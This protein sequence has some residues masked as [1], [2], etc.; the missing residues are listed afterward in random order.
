MSS[1]LLAATSTGFSAPRS[2]AASSLSPGRMPVR[3]STTRTAT[4]DSASAWRA[5]DCTARARSSSSSRSTPPV[6]TSTKRRPFH[7]V[8]I[9]L[10]SRVTPDCSWTTAS[11]VPV[12]RLTSVDLPTLGKPTMATLGRAIGLRALPLAGQV[13]DPLDYLVDRQVAGVDLDGVV[14]RHQRRV[15]ALL[16]LLVAQGLVAQDDLV[17]GPQ[18][19]GAPAGAR[20][21]AGRQ[22]DLEA[23]VGRDD[24]ADVAALGHP[25]A[26][27]VEQLALLVDERGAHGLQGG[28]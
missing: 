26:A 25:V 13:R 11:R 15:L 1:T 3:A 28:D 4:S 27:V 19:V 17:V 20:L 24:R 21:W 22:E 7:S 8:S 23:R 2:S 6:S 16:V 10:R 5:C 9:S 18:L 12:R 14:R